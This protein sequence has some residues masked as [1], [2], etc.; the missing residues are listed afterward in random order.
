MA[1]HDQIERVRGNVVGVSSASNDVSDNL[2]SLS[3][4]L[5]DELG[6]VR[7]QF[8]LSSAVSADSLIG[9]SLRCRLQELGGSIMDLIEDGFGLGDLIKDFKMPDLSELGAKLAQLNPLNLLDSLGDISLESVTNKVGE[10]IN[11]AVGFIGDVIDKTFQSVE[12][13]MKGI[14]D[15]FDEFGD[16]VADLGG[17]VQDTITGIVGGVGQVLQDI[18]QGIED[19][20]GSLL[21]PCPQP[22][23]IPSVQA[24]QSLQADIEMFNTDIEIVHGNIVNV[25]AIADST[26]K[27]SKIVT[28]QAT[29][30]AENASS[31]LGLSIPLAVDPKHAAPTTDAAAA[32][33]EENQQRDT[34]NTQTLNQAKDSTASAM[35]EQVES[36]KKQ[37]DQE[38]IKELL[39]TTDQT[40]ENVTPESV[41]DQSAC[42]GVL[43]H[44]DIQY[45][46]VKNLL[47]VMTNSS[48]TYSDGEPSGY[49]FVVGRFYGSQ[50][51]INNLIFA[52]AAKRPHG[53]RWFMAISGY[54]V[55][56]ALDEYQKNNEWPQSFL[57][58]SRSNYGVI[59]PK[60]MNS[61]VQSDEITNK[62]VQSDQSKL[63]QCIEEHELILREQAIAALN[64]DSFMYPAYRRAEMDRTDRSGRILQQARIVSFND[65]F[66]RGQHVTWKDIWGGHQIEAAI[67]LTHEPD[68]ISRMY[69]DILPLISTNPDFLNMLN[70]TDD[71]NQQ[72]DNSGIF[73]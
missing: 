17:L 34:L 41:F 47:D 50:L 54:P 72:L 51:T 55:Y 67:E 45:N 28:Q 22:S 21:A 33:A 23:T 14:G 24:Q 16:R 36:E 26:G 56:K 9:D 30:A 12:R 40:G 6:G 13:A 53:E 39:S 71:L 49:K 37:G 2:S 25:G 4:R 43:K 63:M 15:M 11:D 3:T 20:V 58:R 42:A 18:T 70:E 46:R 44:F 48:L 61:L 19:I 29:H 52:Y 73:E 35:V 5:S 60:H 27:F 62:M 65:K 8:G 68:G 7:D 31:G 38:E 57:N 59:E 32:N 64:P 1:V 66:T 69:V 10:L